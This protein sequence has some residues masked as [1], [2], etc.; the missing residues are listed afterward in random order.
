MTIEIVFME[1]NKPVASVSM[2]CHSLY[3]TILFDLSNEDFEKWLPGFDGTED[4]TVTDKECI[5]KVWNSCIDHGY[6]SRNYDMLSI[7]L[8]KMKII[9]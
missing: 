2:T 5:V 8:D 9:A 1:G 4:I 6:I 3:C 7:F